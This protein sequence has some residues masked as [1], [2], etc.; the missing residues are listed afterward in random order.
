MFGHYCFNAYKERIRKQVDNPMKVSLLSVFMMVL[1]VLCIVGTLVLILTSKADSSI[2]LLYGFCIF[3]GWITAIILGMTFKTLPFITWNKKFHIHASKGKTPSPKD[4]FSNTI[5]R[6][7]ALSYIA[8]FIF[9]G[10]GLIIQQDFFL[11][12]GALLLIIS[13]VLYSVNVAKI[14]F[15]KSQRS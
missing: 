10:T 11:K 3:F 15:Y 2:V 12:A 1:P 5:F 8:G 9:F 7:M 14:L 13:S 6:Y 4:L